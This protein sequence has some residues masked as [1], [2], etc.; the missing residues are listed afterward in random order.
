MIIK[1]PDCGIESTDKDFDN[2]TEHCSIW[3]DNDGKSHCECW[4]CSKEWIQ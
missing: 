3:T 1:C 4:E 2:N